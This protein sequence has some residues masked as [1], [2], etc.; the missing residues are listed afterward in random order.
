MGW[1]QTGP[2][3]SVTSGKVVLGDLADVAGTAIVHQVDPVEPVVAPAEMPQG[4][5]VVL[6]VVG[7]QAERLHLPAMD[8]QE[9][10]DVDR[11]VSGIVVL[12][13]L[14]RARDGAA[15]RHPLQNLAVGHLVSAHD[16][17][18][19]RSQPLGVGVAPEDL[20]CPLLEA[21]RRR[22]WFAN[23]VSDGVAGQHHRV[24]A[25]LSGG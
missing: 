24:S 21:A 9:I 19:V 1:G 3:P 8:D 22:G 11:A 20:L 7:F 13:L 2:P 15:D 25:G 23:T 17:D 10:Q 5:D 4:C 16:P 18:P 14:D 12:R 6:G